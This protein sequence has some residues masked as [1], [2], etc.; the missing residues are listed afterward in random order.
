VLPLV[1]IVL[2]VFVLMILGLPVALAFGA[3]A[4]ALF[5]TYGVDAAW[6]VSQ[7]LALLS[8]FNFLALPLYVLLGAT[9]ATAGLAERIAAFATSLTGRIKGGLGIA[10]IIAN[11]LFGAMSGSSMS[12]LAGM[13]KA[14]LPV[15]E[16]EGY[17]REYA[18]S[19]LI[20]SAVLSC[21]IPPSGFLVT[22][23]F[24]S[25]LSIARTFLAGIL[26]AIILILLMIVVHLFM[27][28]RI[29]T[30]KVPEK[31]S[32][33][34][35]V[36][37]VFSTGFRQSPTLLIPLVVLGVIYAGIGT[38]T[39]SAGAGVIYAVLLGFVVYRTIKPRAMAGALVDTGA[40]IG[41]IFILFFF[42]IAFSRVLIIEQVSDQLLNVMLS[43]SDN[44]YVLL[45]MLNLLML[46]LGMLMDDISTGVINA[47]ILL[48]IATSLGFDPYH[49]AA[50]SVVNLEI[51][52]LTPPVAPLLYLGGS[53]AGDIPIA[54]Y[55]KPVVA[56]IL[57]AF[58]PTL[59][60]TMFIPELGSLLPT[61]YS[62]H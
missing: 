4:I 62:P 39:E 33:Q 34:A 1:F 6:A 57:F 3:G 41:T 30:I 26:P 60:L 9:I 52:L 19:L 47:L 49:W 31:M 8:S 12:A 51:G 37:S 45:L 14:F 13:G 58:I 36:K 10:I 15:M 59:L 54:R 55:I 32:P 46:L 17:P 61:S 2:G 44:R 40:T 29:P 21:L 18:V 28:R 25:G 56:F 20:P 24:L 22:F 16:K 7:S 43:I 38:P 5:F 11:A 27:C 42:F 23:G 35:Q 50:I 53:I 48:P